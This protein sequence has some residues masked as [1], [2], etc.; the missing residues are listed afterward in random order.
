VAPQKLAVCGGWADTL[1]AAIA[2]A[3]A[4]LDR[5]THAREYGDRAYWIGTAPA[6]PLVWT[7]EL[8]QGEEVAEY[9]RDSR[10]WFAAVWWPSEPLMT[11]NRRLS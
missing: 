2:M 6:K 8:L 9:K 10:R 7:G 4:E 11:Q 3:E 5:K 1:Q